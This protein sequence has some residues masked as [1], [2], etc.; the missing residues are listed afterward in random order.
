MEQK[1]NK[2][3]LSFNDIGSGLLA[4][5]NASLKGFAIADNSGKF[6]W[7]NAT[8]EEDKIVV[9]NDTIS[10]PSKVR[11]AWADNPIEANLYNKEN[12]PASPF[13]SDLNRKK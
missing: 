2:L 9:W 5:D 4:K 3:I 6:V 8:I 11:Y 13:E 12:L 10:N 1:G 7:A